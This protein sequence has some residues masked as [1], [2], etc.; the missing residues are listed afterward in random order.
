MIRNEKFKLIMFL[1]YT[2]LYECLVWIGFFF[3]V[4]IYDGSP[5]WAA[6]A[7]FMS[8]SQLKPKHF[9]LKYKIEKADTD[10]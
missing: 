5:W 6:L 9:G 7:V 2:I 8:M 3:I 4:F 10:E 1:V